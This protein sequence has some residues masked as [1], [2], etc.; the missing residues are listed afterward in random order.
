MRKIYSKI[1]KKIQ[2]LTI[3]HKLLVVCLRFLIETLDLKDLEELA[4]AVFLMQLPEAMNDAR[5]CGTT[6]DSLERRVVQ[7][8]ACALIPLVGAL[9][10]VG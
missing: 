5:C 6:N 7:A 1:G 10:V 3:S 4:T 8:D 9:I 2:A